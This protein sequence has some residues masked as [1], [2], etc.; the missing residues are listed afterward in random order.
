MFEINLFK[1]RRDTIILLFISFSLIFLKWYFAFVVHPVEDINLK[2]IN[3]IDDS[4]YLPLI[5]SFSNFDFAPSFNQINNNLGLISFPILGLSIYSL[6]YK[7]FGGYGFIVI[8]F[9]SVFFF[10]I[11][12]L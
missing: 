4:L 5:Y 6:F 12:F 11:Y 3:E 8:Q 7:I 9:L 1:L 10:F 2:I